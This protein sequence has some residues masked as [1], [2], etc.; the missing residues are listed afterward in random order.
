MSGTPIP[1]TQGRS[2]SDEESEPGPV[3]KNPDY[4]HN[5]K[6]LV[7]AVT[8]KLPSQPTKCT[9]IRLHVHSAAWG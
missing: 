6:V 4:S 8:G 3:G 9:V 7:N 5:A 2:V 1:E